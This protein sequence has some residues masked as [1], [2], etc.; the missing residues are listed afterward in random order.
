MARNCSNPAVDSLF[1][2]QA[3]LVG[4]FRSKLPECEDGG[5]SNIS[6]QPNKYGICKPCGPTRNLAC[7]PGW[8][9]PPSRYK[10]WRWQ[11][12]KGEALGEVNPP[13][14]RKCK[15]KEN[16]YIIHADFGEQIVFSLWIVFN[17]PIYAPPPPSQ[18]KFRHSLRHC[19]QHWIIYKT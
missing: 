16:K 6:D 15:K 9:H 10:Q 13:L 1:A 5:F 3:P 18:R 19:L 4:A 14:M 2:S 17:R 11:W 12:G 8:A 7:V